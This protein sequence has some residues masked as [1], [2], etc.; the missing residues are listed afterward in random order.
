MTDIF[1]DGV[2]AGFIVG[3]VLAWAIQKERRMKELNDLH[4]EI[5]RIKKEK[6]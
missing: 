4:D 3:F 5:E 6:Q 2:V 1:I